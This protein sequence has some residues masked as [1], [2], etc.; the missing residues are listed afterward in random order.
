MSEHTP[1]KWVVVKLTNKQ[2]LVHYRVFATWYGGYLGGDAWRLNSGITAVD[3]VDSCYEFVG[4]S[5]SVYRC[6]R[7]GYGTTSHG[8]GVLNGLIKDS[9]ELVNMEVMPETTE[10]WTCW[11]PSAYSTLD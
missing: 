6:R 3:L 1:D 4:S 11:L 7:D 2:D 10:W 8:R 5:G 9:V